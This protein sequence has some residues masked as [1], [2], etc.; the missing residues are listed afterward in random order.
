M[1]ISLLCPLLPPPPP[2]SI[3]LLRPLRKDEP[4]A[5][6]I[7]GLIALP[8]PKRKRGKRGGGEG[9]VSF[10]PFLLRDV[11]VII[12]FR[13]RLQKKLSQGALAFL[14]CFAV[15]QRGLPSLP[16]PPFLFLSSASD[17]DFEQKKSGRAT[18]GV[19]LTAS[20]IFPSWV[21]LG[22]MASSS[23]CEP[24]ANDSSFWA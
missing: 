7:S 20:V 19:D 12:F 9:G 13:L 21:Y 18:M 5:A 2:P 4:K 1:T 23:P 17:D 24:Y 3:S 15:L 22:W 16:C 14:A 10:F 11:A 6:Q 8:G